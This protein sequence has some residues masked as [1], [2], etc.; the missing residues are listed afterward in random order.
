MSTTIKEE[1]LTALNLK[2]PFDGFQKKEGVKLWGW[3]GDSPIFKYL[4]DQVNI[5]LLFRNR[6]AKYKQHA[7]AVLWD[8]SFQNF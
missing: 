1:V 7:R 4:I 5:F 6:A 2:D 3:N 8:R